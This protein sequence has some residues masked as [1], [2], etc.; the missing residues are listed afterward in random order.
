[1]QNPSKIAKYNS[2]GSILVIISS[3]SAFCRLWTFFE[4]LDIYLAFCHFL[5]SGLSS[6][7]LVRI[8]DL[9]EGAGPSP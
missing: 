1:M 2:Y 5:C 6:D 3:Q 7:L 4:S 9:C 8:L